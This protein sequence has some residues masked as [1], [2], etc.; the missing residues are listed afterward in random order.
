MLTLLHTKNE[1]MAAEAMKEAEAQC[2]AMIMEVEAHCATQAYI[3]EQSHQE[4]MLK[5]RA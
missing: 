1:T 4:S 5:L 3:L 2:A